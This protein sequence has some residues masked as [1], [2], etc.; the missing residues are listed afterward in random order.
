MNDWN[1]DL[2]APCLCFVIWGIPV[3]EGKRRIGTA[4]L[5]PDGAGPAPSQQR[6]VSGRAS[7]DVDPV[8]TA[9]GGRPHG[10]LRQVV[11]ELQFGIIE[12]A[13]QSFPNGKRESAC[14]VGSAAGQH[15]P[16]H[17]EY[18]SADFIEL[19]RSLLMALSMVCG[20]VHL[21]VSCLRI[22]RE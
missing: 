21:F 9:E 5:L 7:P 8:A 4:R 14:L 16:A 19:R 3:D 17:I 15:C 18:V 13:Y 20:V 12:E 11:T 1:A 6:A 22:D 2:S 10:I